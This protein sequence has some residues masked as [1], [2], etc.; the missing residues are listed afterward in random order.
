MAFIRFEKIPS[1]P[2]SV[3]LDEL[4]PEHGSKLAIPLLQISTPLVSE[5]APGKPTL[6]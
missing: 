3:F 6:V 2:L 5:V 1:S 4:M